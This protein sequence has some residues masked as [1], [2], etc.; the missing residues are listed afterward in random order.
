MAHTEL[1]E[2]FAFGENWE[3]FVRTITHEQIQS[4]TDDLQ[5]LLG[6]SIRGRRFLD[7]GSGSGLHSLAALRL[8]ASEVLALD[9]DPVSV[10]TTQRLLER[11]APNE[12]LWRAEQRSALELSP[13]VLG[14]FDIVYSWGV[15]HHTGRMRQAM[16]T[17][18]H[19]VAPRGILALALYER[20]FFCPAWR[21][22]KFIYSRSPKSIQRIAQGIYSGL[23]RSARRLAGKRNLERIR[24]MDYSHDLHDWL[25]GYPYE[26]IES[27]EC[28][29]FMA[30]RSFSPLKVI[31][32][33]P[34]ALGL[35][36][37]GCSEFVFQKKESDNRALH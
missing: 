32:R 30:E 21:V 16:A 29:R 35:F 15:L 2:H 14:T 22:E 34:R 25:G 4:A 10:K 3:D 17:V 28:L 18:A 9:L 12:Y 11:F 19:M 23:Y 37:S 5:N 27:A 33:K 20:S 36:G 7:V 26:S 31:T 8:G 1:R 6:D 24:G 13:E